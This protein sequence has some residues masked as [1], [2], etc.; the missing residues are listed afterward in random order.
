DLNVGRKV[1]VKVLPKRHSDNQEF[2]TRFRREA[3]ATGKLN[4]VNIVAAY[5]VDEERGLHYYAMEY[6]E[7]EPLDSIL[8]R[9]HFIQWDLAANVV[10]QVARGLK[11]AHEHG[12]IHR[13]IKPANIFICKP[14]GPSRDREGAVGPLA[15]ARGSE[16]PFA[17]GFVA[18]I[19][20][21]GLSK[22]LGSASSFYTQTGLALGTP[23]YISPEQ[24]KG[25]RN[26][27]G[28]TD[29]Y[30]LGAT[31]YHLVTG[32]TPF[33]AST[34]MV[35]MMKHVNEQ[36]PNPQDIRDEIPDGVVH[37]IQKM[38]AKAPADRYRDCKELLDDLELVIDGK[39]PSSQAI[40][41]GKSSVAVARVP[42]RVPLSLGGRA[43]RR[44]QRARKLQ[45]GKMQHIVIGALGLGALILVLALLLGGG[46]KKS[47]NRAV[48]TGSTQSMPSIP[49]TPD[50]AA[51][52][53]AEPAPPA[54]VPPAN[55]A[56]TPKA[57]DSPAV[58]P[59]AAP[60][61][62]AER[63]WKAVFD[64]KTTDCLAN[65]Q[66]KSA[67]RVENGALV[68]APNAKGSFLRTKM[69]FGD[70][71]IRV[72]FEVRG[73][74][75]M[76]FHPRGPDAGWA[77]AFVQ[78]QV[79]EMEAKPQELIAVCRGADVTVLLNGQ[80]CKV[81]GG[82][83]LRHGE[84]RLL[85]VNGILR[86]RTIEYRE[87]APAQL[88]VGQKDKDGWTCIFNGRD[89][90]GWG[91]D[92]NGTARVE[93]GS[94]IIADSAFLRR[95][96]PADFELRGEVKLIRESPGPLCGGVYL[97][98]QHRPSANLRV[99]LYADGDIH[100]RSREGGTLA[101][102]GAKTLTPQ[103]WQPFLMRVAGLNIAVTAGG[104]TIA[105]QVDVLEKGDLGLNGS[106]EI[107]FKDL[108]LC[109]LG[110][111]GKPLQPKGP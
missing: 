71:E 97:R 78:H 111:D 42:R 103:T 29:I 25:D 7:G 63:P 107:A 16:D 13:D 94:L 58:Q 20:D 65:S 56:E 19:L 70:A 47:G 9:E 45:S 76:D 74:M 86:V 106:G 38:M 43:P 88:E 37:V 90:T 81:S 72:R 60:D 32:E 18:K 75:Y 59:Q 54:G 49:S 109:E 17:E 79:K 57:G 50:A 52:L 68:N 4:H 104:K 73:V 61:A 21:L 35:I 105:A 77:V 110:P 40:E 26:V 102:A 14:L 82:G 55:K 23:H 34:P 15:D 10:L 93:G 92:K 1:A 3:Q 28:R 99:N 27:D 53:N 31:F 44:A 83:A 108:W 85:V 39:M 51:K 62:G 8:K 95:E 84:L 67:W 80:P 12:I 46:G 64:G 100:I 5:T 2:L 69:A 41:M 96:A 89:L 22:T 6:C 98:I 24:A 87:L 91:W 11:H 48:S 30:S 101:R 66:Y 33:H 36:L